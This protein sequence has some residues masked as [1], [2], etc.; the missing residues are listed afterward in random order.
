[1]ER[2]RRP[3]HARQVRQHELQDDVSH[4]VV[5]YYIGVLHLRLD[6]S[7]YAPESRSGIRNRSLHHPTSYN[8]ATG[9]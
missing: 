7:T 6:P 4:V 8:N 2:S 1:M 3:S 5:T 9:R